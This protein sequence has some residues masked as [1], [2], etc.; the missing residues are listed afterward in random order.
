MSL[1]VSSSCTAQQLSAGPCG[2]LKV[3]HRVRRVSI[4][5]SS[6]PTAVLDLFARYVSHQRRAELPRQKQNHAPSTSDEAHAVAAVSAQRAAEVLRT[7]QHCLF[8]AGLL[9][10]S[11]C[12]ELPETMCGPFVGAPGTKDN[13][14]RGASARAAFASAS[15]ARLAVAVAGTSLPCLH[16]VIS[17]S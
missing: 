2:A 3:L 11:I 12:R 1:G 14:F 10:E 8:G 15:H 9:R 13:S 6:S 4:F 7:H 16:P 5:S 17:F